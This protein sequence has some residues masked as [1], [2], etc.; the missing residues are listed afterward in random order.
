MR[1]F[2]AP[3]FFSATI[4]EKDYTDAFKNMNGT[5]QKNSQ[6]WNALTQEINNRQPPPA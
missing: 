6:N 4:E 3:D 5:M 2:L 1:D